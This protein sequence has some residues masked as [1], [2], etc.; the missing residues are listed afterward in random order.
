MNKDTFTL[1]RDANAERA[2]VDGIVSLFTD[3]WDETSKK[4]SRDITALV[5]MQMKDACIVAPKGSEETEES[6][7]LK[8]SSQYFEKTIKQLQSGEPLKMVISGSNLEEILN[9][10]ENIKKAAKGEE[11]EEDIKKRI[12]FFTTKLNKQIEQLHQ[13]YQNEKGKLLVKSILYGLLFAGI[14]TLF[15]NV[16]VGVD[17]SI[18][19][20]LFGWVLSG[21]MIYAALYGKLNSR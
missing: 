12:S 5:L 19:T 8:Y 4:S 6:R 13:Q 3:K 10:L 17:F 7:M 21:V 15:V 18:S 9:N 11:H 20:F 1:K 2:A 16:G 14:M